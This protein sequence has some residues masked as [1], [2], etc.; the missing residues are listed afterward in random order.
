MSDQ[1]VKVRFGAD[2]AELKSGLGALKGELSGVFGEIR[3]AM[4]GMAAQSKEA[5]GQVSESF[6]GL[7]GIAESLGG[8]FAGLASHIGLIG[9]VMAGGA[10]FK[11]AV[12]AVSA[13]AGEVKRLANIFG[14]TAEAAN[15]LHIQLGLAGMG[16]DEYV[17]AAMKL[18][19]QLKINEKGLNQVGVATRDAN[20]ALLP[21]ADL[22]QNAVDAMMEYKAGTDRNSFAMLAFGKSAEDAYALLKLNN[23]TQ[24]EATRLA[25]AGIGVDQEALD[26]VKAFNA[27]KRESGLILEDFISKVGEAVMPIFTSL[28]KAV[29]NLALTVFPYFNAAVKAIGAVLSA[30]GDV[31]TEVVDD[32]I[33]IFKELEAVEDMVFHSLFG[34][35]DHFTMLTRTIVTTVQVLKVAIME[36]MQTVTMAVDLAIV[37]F[38]TLAN[39]ALHAMK[40]DWNGA[41]EAAAAG[42]REM[43]ATMMEHAKNMVKIA[44]DAAAKV[45]AAWGMKEEKKPKPNKGHKDFHEPKPEKQE[46][47]FEIMK[48]ELDREKDARD[49]A[50]QMTL[51]EEM[52]FWQRML[53]TTSTGTLKERE[54][55][56]KVLHEVVTI[57]RELYRKMTEDA[58]KAAEQWVKVQAEGLQAQID[59]V[60]AKGKAEQDANKFAFE[61]GKITAQQRATLDQQ[62]D[63]KILAQ[64]LALYTKLMDL[65][66]NNAEEQAKLQKDMLKLMDE[67]DQKKTQSAQQAALASQKAW[68]GT[69]NTIIST[70][71][72]AFD[73]ILMKQ[74][75]LGKA[76]QKMCQ[77]M[78]SDLI[79]AGAEMAAK[80][81]V[82]EL[83]KT[84]AT[85]TGNA[86]RT[87]A[88]SSGQAA[89]A[90][91]NIAAVVKSIMASASETFAGIF[92]FLSPEM[93]PAAAAPAAAGMAA[94]KA[95]VPSMAGGE[96]SVPG[97]TFA[98]IHKK[99]MVM[100]AKYAGPL[101]EMVEGGGGGGGGNH[102]H[103]HTYD[104]TG[105]E[106]L[107]KNNSRVLTNVMKDAMRNFRK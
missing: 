37:A 4:D 102:F 53:A 78:V 65:Q 43:E 61:L 9:K 18:D 27:A 24:Q 81:A 93:G 100:P 19:R 58:K 1:D 22:L 87:A 94:V 10:M 99:E 103:V 45:A 42:G 14:I 25:A 29:S 23:Q 67:T 2:T 8:A 36:T 11:E 51:S 96:W 97:D 48:A 16:T 71:G 52:A 95:V 5:M 12:S 60:K 26:A 44:E 70:L 30:V 83:S 92:G 41:K 89:A 105:V 69:A 79:K 49:D 64:E 104:R 31:I 62:V 66:I 59:D 101:R 35:V 72:T 20:G 17:G 54:L 28:A 15:R 32:V 63:D 55:H 56:N 98:Y 21:Q 107:L 47:G 82:Y 77:Q 86:A 74:S 50:H 34:N 46:D 57:R 91:A 38:K 13:E 7:H 40:L 88:D 6:K 76:F 106:G 75:S 33:S 68:E 80:W 73:S 3:S 39:V 90:A 84:A 85:V